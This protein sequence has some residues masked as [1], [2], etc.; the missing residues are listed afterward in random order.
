MKF[1]CRELV[2]YV[3]R[4]G[5]NTFGVYRQ[6]KRDLFFTDFRLKGNLRHSTYTA[7]GRRFTVFL[8]V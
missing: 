8:T 5:D 2:L 6:T 4:I 3:H 1:N 7:L